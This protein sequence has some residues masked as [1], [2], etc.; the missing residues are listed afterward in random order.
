MACVQRLLLPVYSRARK[1]GKATWQHLHN[2]AL[3]YTSD[4]R[5]PTER[6]LASFTG[7]P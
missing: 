7:I 5:N 6:H 4:Q 2:A 3:P 1:V